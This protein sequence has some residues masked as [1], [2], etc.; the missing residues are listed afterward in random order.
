MVKT[1]WHPRDAFIKNIFTLIAHEI[2]FLSSLF[3]FGIDSI[4][5]KKLVAL[6][7]I[8][9]G[10]KVLDVCTGTGKLAFLL[11]REVGARGSSR[12]G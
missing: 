12:W 5:R 2:D 1:P 3:S 7:K 8:K 11:S 4:W 10:E 9:N 6:A